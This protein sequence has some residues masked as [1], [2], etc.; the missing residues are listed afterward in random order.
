MLQP[1]YFKMR[2]IEIGAG[3]RF[4]QY[5]PSPK[6]APSFYDRVVKPLRKLQDRGVVEKVQ[7]IIAADEK[8]PMAVKIIGPVDLTKLSQP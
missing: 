5:S 4:W 7:E 2:L 6:N 3:R 8:T 1:D